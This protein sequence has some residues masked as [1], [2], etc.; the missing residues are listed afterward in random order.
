MTGKNETDKDC[1]IVKDLLPLYFDGVCSDESRKLV[2]AHV[3]NCESC[4]KELEII[5]E[6][7]ERRNKQNGDEKKAFK[8]FSKQ[9]RRKIAAYILLSFAVV[10]LG[11]YFIFAYE[12]NVKYSDDLVS[13][14]I[15]VDG[16]ID[17]YINVKN[18]KEAYAVFEKVSENGYNVYI[19]AV[20]NVITKL[21]PELDP[22]DHLVRIGNNLC[23]DFQ[24]DS[25]RFNLPENAE[26]ERIYYYDGNA[27]KLNAVVD[28]DEFANA[29]KDAVLIWEK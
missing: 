1:K 16:G 14:T 9:V 10:L 23:F 7:E 24:S 25:L 13:V 2:E 21:A 4:A 19:T 22:T 11:Y 5:S 29:V 20:N 6:Y 3:K 17:I 18:Y 12:F 15:P 28:S 27:Q 8:K 26:V